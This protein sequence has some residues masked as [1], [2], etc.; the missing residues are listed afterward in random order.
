MLRLS[1]RYKATLRDNSTLQQCEYE[2]IA[3]VDDYEPR[4][5]TAPTSR[6]LQQFS[7]NFAQK[8]LADIARMVMASFDCSLARDC[9]L[10]AS[11]IS[12]RGQLSLLSHPC[13][14]SF[15]NDNDGYSDYANYWPRHHDSHLVVSFQFR[16]LSSLLHTQPWLINRLGYRIRVGC[17]SP[18]RPFVDGIWHSPLPGWRAITIRVAPEPTD[19]V[20][21]RLADFLTA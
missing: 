3:T 6:C 17:F 15:T 1:S 4:G 2:S 11:Y 13:V 21:L 20:Y 16:F 14:H 5:S 10:L 19:L 7:S 8:S 18:T 9:S 12:S